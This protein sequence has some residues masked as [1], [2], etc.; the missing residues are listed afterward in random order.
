MGGLAAESAGI[1]RQVRRL[2]REK[3]ALQGTDIWGQPETVKLAGADNAAGLV[4]NNTIC[5]PENPDPVWQTFRKAYIEKYKREPTVQ[6]TKGYLSVTLIAKGIKDADS[7]EPT[8]LRDGLGRIKG[9]KTVLGQFTTDE[10]GDGLKDVVMVKIIDE[11]KRTI[12][13]RNF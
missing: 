3:V 9:F 6:A 2:F 1:T 5:V 12:V 4:Y 13:Y 7:A 10:F 8:K 11:E